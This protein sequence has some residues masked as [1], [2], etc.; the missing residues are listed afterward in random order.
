MTARGLRSGSVRAVSMQ[1][2]VT[3]DV[4]LSG[5]SGVAV[6]NDLGWS[7]EVNLAH[8][9]HGISM[10]SFQALAPWTL[11]MLGCGT[12]RMTMLTAY[13]PAGARPE[14]K[15]LCV[16]VPGPPVKQTAYCCP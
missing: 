2:D 4:S 14:A 13:M 3:T 1:S 6:T 7:D 11:A 9:A 16:D 12:T 8:A 5:G 15:Q 10:T